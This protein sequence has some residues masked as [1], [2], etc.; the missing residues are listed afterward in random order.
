MKNIIFLSLLVFCP[1]LASGQDYLQQANACFEK[2]DYEC[3][4]QKYALFKEFDGSRDVS[5]QIQAADE[6]LRTLILAD[7]YFKDKEF[8][9][10]KGKYKIVLDKNP[11]DPY[12]KKQYDACVKQINASASNNQPSQ[13]GNPSGNAVSRTPTNDL[14]IAMIYVQGGTFTMGCTQEQGDDCYDWEK[15]AHQVTLSSFYIGKYEV[16]QAE[17]KSVMATNPSNFKGDNLPV[18]NVSWNDVQ[19]FIRKLNA[20]TGKQYRLPTEA[21]W[22]YACRGG[23]QS[24]HYKYS[25]SN[26]AGNVAWYSENSSNTTHPVGTK[27]PNELGIYDMSGNVWEWCSDWY[28]NYSASDQMNPQGPSSGSNRV[29]RGGGWDGDAGYCRVSDRNGGAPGS[30]Y[31][32]LGFRLACSSN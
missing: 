3:A 25:G 14:S 19:E 26:T 32:D 20:Q 24:A 16:T 27:S 7:G 31:N 15:P 28:G 18:E 10:A 17:W 29:F 5:A 23:M 21:E 9:K 8:A 1:L 12:A 2:G 30:R 11:K 6:C 22:E 4:K 13:A